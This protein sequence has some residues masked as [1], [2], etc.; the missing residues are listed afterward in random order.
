MFD[1]AAWR[2]GE[3]GRA[4]SALNNRVGPMMVL[5]PNKAET[6]KIDYRAGITQLDTDGRH[7]E[8]TR[9]ANLHP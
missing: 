5:M 8:L 4:E 2:D 9:D 1:K 7:G 3:S 6:A